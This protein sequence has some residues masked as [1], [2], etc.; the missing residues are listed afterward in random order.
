[1]QKCFLCS[2]FCNKLLYEP[3]RNTEFTARKL[4]SAI[5]IILITYVT[6]QATEA[7]VTCT[8]YFDKD[9]STSKYTITK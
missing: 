3:I 8:K 7:V 9:L 6:N 5:I 4:N 2:F 1:M